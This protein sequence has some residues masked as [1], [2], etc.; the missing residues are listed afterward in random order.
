[1]PLARRIEAWHEAGLA[2]EMDSMEETGLRRFT[3]QA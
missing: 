1:L 3:A 2:V